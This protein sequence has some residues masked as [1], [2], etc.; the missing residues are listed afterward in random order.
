MVRDIR[1]ARCHYAAGIEHAAARRHEIIL[2]LFI[3][4]LARRD[5][6]SFVETEA[7]AVVAIGVDVRQH[8]DEV[9]RLQS[10]G[11]QRPA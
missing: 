7:R 10:L 6:N 2:L 3:D 8:R 1:G 9:A 4:R 5:G 11:R